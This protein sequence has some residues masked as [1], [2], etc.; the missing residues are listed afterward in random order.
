VSG[1][2]VGDRHL[3][4]STRSGTSSRTVEDAE[5]AT[6]SWVSWFNDQRIH[7]SIGYRIPTEYEQLHQDQ[8][9]LI[10]AK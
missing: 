9:V 2:Q 10:D 8:Q 3:P 7:S 5:L 6:L 4:S 1:H